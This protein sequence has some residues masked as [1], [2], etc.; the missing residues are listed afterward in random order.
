MVSF[1]EFKICFT[2][3]R[4]HLIFFCFWIFVYKVGNRLT[5]YHCVV[6]NFITIREY[7][8]NCNERNMCK[9]FLKMHALVVKCMQ[10]TLAFH[11]SLVS[12][13]RA[14]YMPGDVFYP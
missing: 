11:C 8:V 2:K 10:A 12:C 9:T 6:A 4:K 5:L 14:K 13:I 3:L 1:T 7:C